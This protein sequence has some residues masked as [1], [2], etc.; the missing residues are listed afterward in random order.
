M[1]IGLLSFVLVIFVSVVSKAA[2]DR[3]LISV[4]GIAETMVDPNLLTLQIDSWAKGS[5]AKVAQEGQAI[6]YKKILN[7]IEK[8]KIKKEDFKTENFSVNP[9][10]VY[11][12]KSRRNKITSY[13]TSHQ[14]SIVFKKIE[15]VGALVD[16][17]VASGKNDASSG[18]S[19]QNLIW[20]TDKRNVYETATIQSAVSS[21]RARAEELAQAAGVKIKA[22]HRIIHNN[23]TPERT[24]SMAMKSREAMEDAAPQT[25]LS[26]GKIK[27]RVEV[28]MEFEI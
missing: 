28:Q 15:E 7:V 17:L 13:I 14:I 20:D 23:Y 11:D 6:Q 18:V 1:R 12:T 9:E 16:G 2:E 24:F 25:V 27:I 4:N 22:V 26:P 10:Y 21:A 3:H 8:F 5:T 19:I